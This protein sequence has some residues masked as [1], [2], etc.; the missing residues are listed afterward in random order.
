MFF[1]IYN[2][3]ILLKKL[4]YGGFVVM[5]FNKVILGC[6]PFALGFQF[7]HRS[8]LYELDF[9]D[10]PENIVEVID[11]AYQLGVNNIMLKNNEDLKKAIRL[12]EDNGNRW[13]VT[14]FSSCED[15]RK[16]LEDFS[17]FNVDRVILD[18]LFVDKNLEE[19]NHDIIAEYLSLVQDASY[20][21]A[22]ETRTPFSNLPIIA[23]SSF[24]D[25]FSTVMIPFNFYGYMMDCNFFNKDNRDEFR[26]LVEKLNKTV[27]ANRTLA[28]GILQPQEAYDFI[29]DIDY[30]DEVCV[31]IAKTSEAEET[32]GIIN[33]IL[34]S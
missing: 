16:D 1:V 6:S 10:K 19:D 25:D 11:R 5:T 14:A 24:V 31:G 13:N 21:P 7:G 23:D 20:I 26:I 33:E 27:I 34:K 2:I 15:I 4:C 3:N 12:S 8:R 22:L 29:R 32:L 30:I 17:E 28:T 18:G 9:S